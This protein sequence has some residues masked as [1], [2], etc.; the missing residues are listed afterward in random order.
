M[1]ALLLTLGSHGDI[2]P[3]IAVSQ[4]MARRGDT[5]VLSTNPYFQRQ[6]EAAGVPF[7]PLTE[8]ADLKQI[9]TDHDVMHPTRGPMVV[10]RELTLPLVKGIFDRTRQLIREIRPDVVV[11]HPIVLGAAW[12]CRVEG[13]IPIA[14]I[15]PAPLIWNNPND[16]CVMMPF[17]SRP[18][19]PIGGAVDRMAA[20]WFMRWALDPGL[21]RV[22]RELG[23]PRARDIFSHD[24]VCGRVNLGVWSPVFRP[25]VAGDPAGA[26]ITGF[27]FHDQDHT[28]SATDEELHRFFADGPAPVVFG[29]GS[30]GVH[31]AGRFYEHAVEA[32]T[33]MKMR[34]LLVV[35][36][37]QPPPK[38]L[39]RDGSIK[40]V[41]YAPFSR[42]FPRAAAVV[43]HG[44]IGTTAQGLVSGRPTVITPMAHDQF[45][46]ASR[47]SRL[48]GAGVGRTVRFTRVTPA[49]LEAALREVIEDPGFAQRA[50]AIAARIQHEQ[51]AARAAEAIV[52]VA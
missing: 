52:G 19:G 38:N 42:V 18:P 41:P 17:R 6:I 23:L 32:C 45:D 30:T 5:A 24:A 28:Q 1:K 47:V 16:R 26:A 31:A 3:F 4:A 37:D 43:H 39:P 36:R 29:L 34:A 20:R 48:E 44:G 27:A 22:R 50:R 35:G 49:R 8:H 14:T 7:A 11:L 2:H 40:A 51:G 21:N 25:P 12:A 13:D 33:R 10:L 9:I 46:N 15:S